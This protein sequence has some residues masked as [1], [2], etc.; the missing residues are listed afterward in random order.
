MRRDARGWI[1]AGSLVLMSQGALGASLSTALKNFYAEYEVVKQCQEEAQLS[2]A[3]AERAK[4]AIAKIEAHYLQRDASIDKERLLK[5]A[6]ADK[7]DGYRIATR[8]SN[9]DLKYFCR[10]SLKELLEKAE[11]V[12]PSATGQ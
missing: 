7:N 2:A 10:A 8:N 4:G 9:S 6:V 1:L 11:E 12:G 3:D 5:Q